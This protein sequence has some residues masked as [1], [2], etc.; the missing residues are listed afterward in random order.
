M[1][2]PKPDARTR[3]L[4]AG[5]QLL[6]ERGYD[7]TRVE[8]L[9]TAAGVTKGAFFHHFASKADYGVAA[10]QHWT[11]MTTPM[12]AA[13]DYHAAPTPLARIFAYLDLRRAMIAGAPAQF[14][15]VAGMMA[16]EVFETQPAIRDACGAS[17]AGH[18]ATLEADFAA[19]IA[20]HGLDGVVDAPDLALHTQAVLQGGFVIAKA[21]DDPAAVVASIDHLRRYLMLLFKQGEKLQ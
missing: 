1:S 19:A 8:D 2:T 5:M 18:A 21:L 10:A 7:A 6:R 9:C 11:D 12:F 3:L 15:C 16:Q 20:E 4:D 14:S 17:I 13:A